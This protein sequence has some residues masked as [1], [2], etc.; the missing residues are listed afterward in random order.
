MTRV[1]RYDNPHK[2]VSFAGIEASVSA[3][4]IALEAD[5]GG[6]ST[7]VLYQRGSPRT[8]VCFMHPQ[9]NMTR[10]YAIP[11]L[12]DAGYAAFGQNS[13]Y[14]NND[15]HCIHEVLLLDIA[16]GQRFLRERGYDNVVLIGNSGGG[17]LFALY[18]AQ[19]AT[20]PPGR[21]QETPAGD[22]IDLNAHDLPAADAYVMLAAHLGEGQIL[23]QMIDPSVADEADPLS[24]DASVDPYDP[25]N[26]YR[27]P[28]ESSH[29][30]AEFVERY[31]RGQRDRVARID[32]VARGLIDDRNR[33]RAAMVEPGFANLTSDQRTRTFRRA[34]VHPPMIVHRT[35]ADLR[36]LDLSLDPSDRDAGTLFSYRPDLTNYMELGFARVTTPRAWLSTWSGL[37][38]NASLERNGRGI[39]VPSLVISFDGDNAIF[40]ADA[41]RAFD[42]LAAA[43]K[44]MVRVAGDHYGFSVGTQDRRGATLATDALV[45]WLRARFPAV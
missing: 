6:L 43:D 14:V 18:Q 26:G 17:S 38:S 4:P 27:P 19:A 9:A 28:P 25:A 40:P 12:V 29:Y 42:L 15:T 31:R 11:A 3:E 24:C 41:K 32:A 44:S 2:C 13:R 35:E 21:L 36:A 16:A 1:G 45:A 33:A 5:D 7:A 22:R 39:E 23:M 34:V 10:H 30:D 20:A 8:V 37:S